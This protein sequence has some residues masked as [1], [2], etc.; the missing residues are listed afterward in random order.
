MAVAPTRLDAVCTMAARRED[1]S[2]DLQHDGSTAVRRG[3]SPVGVAQPT[4]VANATM[5]PISTILL[6]ERSGGCMWRNPSGHRIT[7][8][9]NGQAIRHFENLVGSDLP[10][11]RFLLNERES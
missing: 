9:V 5:N 10:P 6:M 2:T 4:N 7:A 3:R 1:A 8:R 11:V